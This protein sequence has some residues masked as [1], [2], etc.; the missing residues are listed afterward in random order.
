MKKLLVMKC[1]D[2]LMW[3]SGL[4]GHVV[5]YEGGWS[6]TPSVFKSRE[7]AGYVNIVKKADAMVIEEDGAQHYHVFNPGQ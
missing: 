7:R 2:S 3:Y 5:P 1:D 4:V 6:D